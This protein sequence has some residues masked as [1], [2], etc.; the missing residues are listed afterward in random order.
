MVVRAV[1]PLEAGRAAEEV[2]RGPVALLVR[3][4]DERALRGWVRDELGY[5]Y[6]VRAAP[7]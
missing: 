6:R 2:S 4:F 3:Q 7:H 1:A 5:H